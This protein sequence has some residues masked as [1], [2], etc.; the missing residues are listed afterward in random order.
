[1]VTLRARYSISN[2]LE[3]FAKVDN[4]FDAEFETFGL[5]GEEPGELDVP[6]ITGMT[7]PVFLGAAP[8]RAGFI[9]IRYRF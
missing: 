5:L 3:I 2:K 1:M 8:P 9:G 7:I 6:L 4:L